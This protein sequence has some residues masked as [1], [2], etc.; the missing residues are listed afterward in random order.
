MEARKAMYKS[1]QQIKQERIEELQRKKQELEQESQ[2]LDSKE[3]KS[4]LQNER[5]KDYKKEQNKILQLSQN[6]YSRDAH[7]N[8]KSKKGH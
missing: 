6:E 8:K 7:K 3:R 5:F 2:G 1:F 4:R